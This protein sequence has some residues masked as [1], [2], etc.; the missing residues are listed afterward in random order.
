MSDLIKLQRIVK[1]KRPINERDGDYKIE[2][3][4]VHKSDIESVKDLPHGDY[5]FS[6]MEYEHYVSDIKFY[7]YMEQL[8]TDTIIVCERTEDII[9]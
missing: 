4:L 6:L 3:I 9:E 1:D 8:G 7:K 2:H 5:K